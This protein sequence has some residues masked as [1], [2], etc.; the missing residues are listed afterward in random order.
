MALAHGHQRNLFHGYA[1]RDHMEDMYVTEDSVFL[2]LAHERFA[3]EQWDRRSGEFVREI[4]HR[5]DHNAVTVPGFHIWNNSFYSTYIGAQLKQFDVSTGKLVRVFQLPGYEFVIQIISAGPRL[6]ART[7]R[8]NVYALD[9]D[10]PETGLK[11]II[12]SAAEGD[13]HECRI[14]AHKDSL[15]LTSAA[16]ESGIIKRFN[17]TTGKLLQ[18]MKTTSFAVALDSTQDDQL[19]VRMFDG[20]LQI[21]NT[22][23]QRFEQSWMT[24]KRTD[25]PKGR[26]N[27]YESTALKVVGDHVYLGGSWGAFKSYDLK[28]GAETFAANISSS[29]FPASVQSIQVLN[30]TLYVG[31]STADVV[32]ADLDGSGAIIAWDVH[33]ALQP[34]STAIIPTMA[35]IVFACIIVLT[36]IKGLK[37]KRRNGYTQLVTT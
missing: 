13:P 17:M 12:S 35:G 15:F 9:L 2:S 10:R 25:R 28:T 18:I 26:Y 8:N 31:L 32:V 5:E 14:L 16:D 36:F 30:R 23:T 11:L 3:V 21:L 4:D 27:Y 1:M 33:R 22:A 19:I 37:L 7:N 6:L 34:S 29:E 24:F 20:H